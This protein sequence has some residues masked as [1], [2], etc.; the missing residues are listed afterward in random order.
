MDEKIKKVD[1]ILENL[2]ELAH[3]ESSKAKQ[4]GYFSKDL[5]EACGVIV[6]LAY[7]RFGKNDK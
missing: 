4:R 6:S 5:A 7:G 3:N 2:I 1:E